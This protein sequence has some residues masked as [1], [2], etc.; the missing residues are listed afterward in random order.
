[1]ASKHVT[2]SKAHRTTPEGRELIA[3]LTEL[4]DDGQVTREEMEQ[5]R[6]WLEVDRSVDV[7]FPA[8]AFLYEVVDT[9]AADGEISEEELDRLVLAIERVLPSDVRLAA[10][11][12]R[13]RYREAR[14]REKS[15]RR[16][17]ERAELRA[18]R[19]AER[20]R[21]KPLHYAD[22]VIAGACR[23]EERREGCESLDVG[24]AVILE[25]EP[26]NRHDSNAILVL[27]EDGSELGYVPRTE[28]SEMAALLDAGAEA[29]ARVKKLLHTH[30]DYVL[31]VVISKLWPEGAS[32][33]ER[34]SSTSSSSTRR[35]SAEQPHAG[36]SCLGVLV[37]V[38][39]TLVAI[40]CHL[41]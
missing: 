30:D 24:D 28:A 19:L 25:R 15:A 13:R 6:Q 10:R 31:P 5:L 7:D 37:I 18:T 34:V 35:S 16:A 14:K 36:C 3:L 27:S 2:L 26:S 9:I 20:Q 38:T 23:S 11:Q 4:S 8:C 29:D 41:R 17:K 22:F 39:I 21:S 12:R 40:S 32:P 33:S 1:M